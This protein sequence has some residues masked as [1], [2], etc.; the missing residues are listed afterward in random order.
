MNNAQNNYNNLFVFL[1]S[2]AYGKTLSG[3]VSLE[4]NVNK[5][6]KAVFAEAKQ[7]VALASFNPVDSDFV[8]NNKIIN[9]KLP[10]IKNRVITTFGDNSY[11]V[12][13]LGLGIDNLQMFYTADGKLEMI[14]FLV[15]NPKKPYPMKCYRHKYPSGKLISAALL[16]SPTESY[17]FSSAGVLTGHWAG[18]NR[19]DKFGNLLETRGY[20]QTNSN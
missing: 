10:K 16:V 6:Q 12:H 17:E 14:A 9:N 3:G 7:K 13:A 18:N 8:K 1:T 20:S 15:F 4:W 5:A 11:A 19:Y 2:F